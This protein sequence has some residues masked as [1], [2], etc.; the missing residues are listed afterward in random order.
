MNF[1]SSPARASG[2]PRPS[3][4]APLIRLGGL[5]WYRGELVVPPAGA[6]EAAADVQLR[7]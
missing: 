1:G 7:P 5:W 3:P 2:E 6:G 4:P